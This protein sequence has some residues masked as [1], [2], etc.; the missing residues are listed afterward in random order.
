MRKKFVTIQ[1]VISDIKALSNLNAVILAYVTDEV[2]PFVT[3]HMA[4]IEEEIR[5]FTSVIIT[6]LQ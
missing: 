1:S 2:E 4:S 6:I 3:T 5:Y